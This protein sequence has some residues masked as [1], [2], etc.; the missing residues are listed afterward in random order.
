MEELQKRLENEVKELEE[1]I[2]E[3]YANSDNERAKYLEGSI[4]GIKFALMYLN[5]LK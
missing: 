2:K 3:A 4:G 5:A 1:A